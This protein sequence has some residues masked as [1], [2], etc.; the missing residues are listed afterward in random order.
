[1][2]LVLLIAECCYL[3]GVQLVQDENGSEIPEGPDLE[4]SMAVALTNLTSVSSLE[5]KMANSTWMLSALTVAVHKALG[6]GDDL[7]AVSDTEGSTGFLWSFVVHPLW[8]FLLLVCGPLSWLEGLVMLP[9]SL[10]LA[11]L[12]GVRDLVLRPAFF[13]LGMTFSM[14]LFLLQLL[15]SPPTLFASGG[16]TANPILGAA[17]I[18]VSL[19][20]ITSPI[21][22]TLL[23]HDLC[24]VVAN[25]DI[26]RRLWVAAKH[27]GLGRLLDRL[28]LSSWGGTS[29]GNKGARAG[30][31]KDYKPARSDSGK[32]E[33]LQAKDGNFV[34]SCFVCLDKPSRYILEPCGHRVVCGDCAVQLVD[35]AARSRPPAEE[36]GGDRGGNCPSCGLAV[37]RVMRMF[38]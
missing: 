25:L 13:L 9:R 7:E 17:F 14:L 28:H 35:A 31:K 21:P 26:V 5:F 38:V 3:L 18:C 33:K 23:A 32:G 34:P 37:N 19:A 16:S 20:A 36:R 27:K 2:I 4:A 11:L 6:P 1:M 12:S 15:F 30:T 8:V 10:I 22:L 29:R 24:R